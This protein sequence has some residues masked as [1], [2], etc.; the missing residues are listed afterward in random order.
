MM[1]WE[2]EYSDRLLEIIVVLFE[3]GDRNKIRIANRAA[4]ALRMAGFYDHTSTDNQKAT[5]AA[6]VARDLR[7]TTAT[8]GAA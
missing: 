1:R 2:G 7:T 4:R 6:L 8:E 5:I 3:N